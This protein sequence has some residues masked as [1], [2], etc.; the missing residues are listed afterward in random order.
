MR[1]VGYLL[2]ISVKEWMSVKIKQ[3]LKLVANLEKLTAKFVPCNVKVVTMGVTDLHNSYPRV[4]AS[5]GFGSN[6]YVF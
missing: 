4:L 3:N 2:Q 5:L 1:Y 6:E